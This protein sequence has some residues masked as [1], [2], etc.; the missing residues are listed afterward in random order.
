[1]IYL[2]PA[3]AMS[4]PISLLYKLAFLSYKLVLIKFFY[5]DVPDLHEKEINWI[6]I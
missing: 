1:M 3:R 2:N 4:F 6:K 5:G